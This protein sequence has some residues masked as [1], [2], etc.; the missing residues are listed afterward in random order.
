MPSTFVTISRRV[1][2]KRETCGRVDLVFH[3]DQHTG[4]IDSLV[5]ASHVDRTT[6]LIHPSRS[7]L[8]L[9]RPHRVPSGIIDKFRSQLVSRTRILIVSMSRRLTFSSSIVLL[10]C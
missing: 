10:F 9:R 4:E 8:H 5:P 2:V 3:H 6:R 1:L 7:S